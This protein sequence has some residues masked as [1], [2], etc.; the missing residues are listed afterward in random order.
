[1]KAANSRNYQAKT[2][3]F[4]CLWPLLECIKLIVIHG[5]LESIILC[6]FS[7]QFQCPPPLCQ[8]VDVIFHWDLF[9]SFHE[10]G[11]IFLQEMK[12]FSQDFRMFSLKDLSSKVQKWSPFSH[13]FLMLFHVK[14]P[15]L[16]TF[17]HKPRQTL[18]TAFGAFPRDPGESSF[19]RKKSP[20]H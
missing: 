6:C 16:S 13:K 2:L 1:M 10:H 3:S 19:W 4:K 15:N 8:I 18:V 9:I 17:A 5:S 20:I 11:W 7:L 12:I 14:L